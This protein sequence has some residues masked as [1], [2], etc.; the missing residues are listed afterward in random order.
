MRQATVDE[1]GAASDVG[2]P[3]AESA[4]GTDRGVRRC[5]SEL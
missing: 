3:A 2:D 5:R 4:W 1:A